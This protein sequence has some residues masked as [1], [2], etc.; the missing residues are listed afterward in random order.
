MPDLK[1]LPRELEQEP[2]Q[3]FWSLLIVK[4]NHAVVSSV[5]ELM[6]KLG[7]DTKLLQRG[8]KGFLEIW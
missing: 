2:L 3:I 8:S 7:Q 5:E 4:P 6:V 1:S